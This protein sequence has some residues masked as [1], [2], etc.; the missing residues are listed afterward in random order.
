MGVTRP[1]ISMV[2]IARDEAQNIERC[3]S[4][5]WA[6]VDEVVL[7][8]TGSTDNTIA[9]ARKFAKQHGNPNKLK[10]V[11][12]E[13]VDDFA[14]A[15]A[16]ADTHATG[17]WLAWCD[18]DDTIEGFA[19]ARVQIEGL[20]AEINTVT[21]RYDYAVDEHG[22]VFSQLWRERVV[23][24]GHGEWQGEI[25]EVK[26]IENAQAAQL[27]PSACRW[28]HHRDHTGERSTR[29]LKLLEAWREREPGNPR[30]LLYLGTELMGLNRHEDAV[31]VFR[32]HIAVEP[33]LDV[34]AGST[35]LLCMCLTTRQPTPL[36]EMRA[37]CAPILVE[38]PTWTDTYLTLAEIANDLQRYEQA[39]LWADRA[40]ELGQPQTPLV[41][42][43]MQYTVHARM[44]RATSL[45]G[46]GRQDEALQLGREIMAVCPDYLNLGGL[47]DQWEGHVGAANGVRALLKL[48]DLLAEQDDPE[49]AL[50]LLECAPRGVCDHP[51]L[52]AKRT[53]LQRQMNGAPWYPPLPADSEPARQLAELL[54]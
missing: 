34:R 23:R 32:E 31:E 11:R 29:N 28:V 20:P 43:P 53:D 19:R 33:H 39:L 8:D 15:R 46:V 25:H 24:H 27:N 50:R 10:I 54:S 16:Y 22:N 47:V 36:E 40:I 9:V 17:E 35:R 18:L 21:A 52:M 1:L 30:C 44:L 42:N 2:L 13:W 4:S 26:I 48:A 37:A 3:F 12:F 38:H 5:W 51:M 14:A 41:I 7:C 6:D 49:R 45:W